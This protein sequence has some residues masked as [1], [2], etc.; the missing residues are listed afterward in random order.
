MAVTP[1]GAR[2]LSHEQVACVHEALI[3]EIRRAGYSVAKNR[4]DAD[5]MVLVNFTPVAGGSGGRVKITGLEPTAPFLRATEQGDTPEARELRRRQREI[6][7]WMERQSRN[8]DA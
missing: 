5:F 3:P 7:Q 6:E 4:A 8:S 1:I 2:S